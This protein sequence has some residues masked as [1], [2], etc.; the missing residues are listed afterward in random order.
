M[1]ARLQRQHLR[2]AALERDMT[3]LGPQLAALEARIEDLH[4]RLTTPAFETSEQAEALSLV[5][6]IR[7]EHQRIRARVTAASRFEERLR[8]LEERVG[9][10]TP[11]QG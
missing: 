4:E 7:R 5:E 11:D 6:E 3:R 10:L 8:Q 2:I 1:A 9:S